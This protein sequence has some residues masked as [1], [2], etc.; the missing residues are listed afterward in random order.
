MPQPSG[1]PYRLPAPKSALR[2]RAVGYKA[3]DIGT[4]TDAVML[5]R[6]FGHEMVSVSILKATEEMSEIIREQM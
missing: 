3:D 2:V 4:T 1:E 5:C 6:M